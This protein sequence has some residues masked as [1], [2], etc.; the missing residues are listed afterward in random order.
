MGVHFARI[1]SGVRRTGLVIRNFAGKVIKELRSNFALILS[2]VTAIALIWQ[3][4]SLRRS[5]ELYEE[6]VRY[7]QKPILVHKI[8]MLE[9]SRLVGTDLIVSEMTL[10]SG[11]L[12]IY[13]ISVFSIESDLPDRP[14][15][16]IESHSDTVPEVNILDPG[17]P[18]YG[19]FT[20][21]LELDPVPSSTAELAYAMYSLNKNVYVHF[22]IIYQDVADRTYVREEG[23]SLA[24]SADS[25]LVWELE[26]AREDEQEIS[27]E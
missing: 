16:F 25:N 5:V 3:T 6:E 26:Y 27:T 13:N 20:V 18:F 1:T 15:D 2:L 12:P 7:Q 4:C 11:R 10:N 21:E 22:C 17:I 24:G 14:S 8:G 23:Y 19:E 9:P